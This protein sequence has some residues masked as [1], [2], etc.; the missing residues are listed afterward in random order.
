MAYVKEV[1]VP[2]RENDPLPL[3]SRLPNQDYGSIE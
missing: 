3:L 1:E 2:V